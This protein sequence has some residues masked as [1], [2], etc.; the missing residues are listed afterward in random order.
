VLVAALMV[1]PAVAQDQKAA[2]DQKASEDAAAAVAAAAA[3]FEAKSLPDKLAV[4]AAC[5]G[6]KGISDT[7]GVPSLAGQPVNFL[8]YQLV[9]MRYGQRKNDVMAP[10]TQDS[11]DD[12]M[13]AFGNYYAALPP[14]PG[15]PDNDPAVTKAGATLDNGHCETCHTVTGQGDIPRLDGQ[16]EDYFIKAMQDYRNGVRSGRGLGVMSEITYSL[17]DDQIRDLA[18]YF[19]VQTGH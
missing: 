1:A 18:H 11:T 17:T 16:R 14:P 15:A 9:F 5:H 19:A 12:D 6:A 3:D 7:E 10:Y 8:E 2:R 13:V 4:C